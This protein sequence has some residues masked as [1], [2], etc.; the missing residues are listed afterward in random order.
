MEVKDILTSFGIIGSDQTP[1]LEKDANVSLLINALA[2]THTTILK[3]KTDPSITGEAV[4]AATK[5]LHESYSKTIV[6][7]GKGIDSTIDTSVF[8]KDG[9]FDHVAFTQKA[10]TDFST[11]LTTFKEANKGDESQKVE[12]IQKSL[13]T[14]NLDLT[15]VRTKL[16]DEIK[17]HEVTVSTNTEDG[18]KRN[19]SASFDKHFASIKFDP[20]KIKPLFIKGLRSEIK[21]NTKQGLDEKGNYVVTKL[22]GSSFD[23][24]HG[25]KHLTIDEIFLQFA[26]T[27]EA[28]LL[29]NDIKKTTTTQTQVKTQDPPKTTG[30]KPY[31]QSLRERVLE[32]VPQG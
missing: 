19:M 7:M 15:N 11:A 29:N 28:P 24:E 4:N 32:G 22:D 8:T 13:D 18:K 25:T 9:V 23:N 20:D 21:D 27:E 10:S 2:K 16:S 30:F 3:A 14:S 6:E 31:N 12:A 17:A 1:M 26:V 5:K